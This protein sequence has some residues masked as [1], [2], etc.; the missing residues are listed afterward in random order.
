MVKYSLV[1]EYADSGMLKSYLNEHFNELKWNDKYQ[2]ALQL[3]NA[4]EFIHECDVIHLDLVKFCT[5]TTLPSFAHY[6]YHV[7]KLI[8]NF[9]KY[10]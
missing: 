10:N 7:I 5:I 4:V 6:C 9:F 1:L 2:L 3:A 8:K